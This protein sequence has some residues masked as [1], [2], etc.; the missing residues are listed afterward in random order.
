MLL[1]L[2]KDVATPASDPPKMHHFRGSDMHL[3]TFLQSSTNIGS[4]RKAQIP[5]SIGLIERWLLK[6]QPFD[7]V[8]DMVTASC[9]NRE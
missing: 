3:S 4:Q 5:N 7:Q 9:K 2:Y 1:G 6:L 8:R